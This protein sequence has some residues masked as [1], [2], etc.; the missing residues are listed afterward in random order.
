[1]GLTLQVGLKGCPSFNNHNQIVL[2]EAF[3]KGLESML[4]KPAPEARLAG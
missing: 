3:K 4:P 1:M 2:Q